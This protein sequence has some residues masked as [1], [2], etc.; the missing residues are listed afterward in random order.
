MDKKGYIIPS[1]NQNNCP[2]SLLKRLEVDISQLQGDI[3]TLKEDIR[4]IKEY[5]IAKKLKED[6]RWIF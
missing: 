3:N 6:N 4:F 2:S 5:I 1:A